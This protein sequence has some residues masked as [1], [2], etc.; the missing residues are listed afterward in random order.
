MTVRSLRGHII[1]S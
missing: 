1:T